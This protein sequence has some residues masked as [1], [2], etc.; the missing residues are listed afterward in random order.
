MPIKVGRWEPKNSNLDRGKQMAKIDMPENWIKE[1]S[2]F[3]DFT[4][5][6]PSNYVEVRCAE[7]QEDG[8]IK[9]VHLESMDMT[10]WKMVQFMHKLEHFLDFIS[11]DYSIDTRVTFDHY[12]NNPVE[13]WGYFGLFCA[14]KYT[15]LI[16]IDKDGRIG[17]HT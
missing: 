2:K 11:S 6:N 7:K 1:L 12:H 17:S 10:T 4:F 13:K 15:G 8:S 9:E 16:L 3:V 14:G 5:G